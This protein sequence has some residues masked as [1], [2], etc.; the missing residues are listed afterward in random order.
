MHSNK[1][2][3]KSE[4]IKN[5][6]SDNIH[7]TESGSKSS[8]KMANKKNAFFKNNAI[9]S[10]IKTSISTNGNSHTTNEIKDT[11][12]ECSDDGEN[13]E[14][15]IISKKKKQKMKISNL[16]RKSSVNEIFGNSKKRI[17]KKSNSIEDPILL[18]SD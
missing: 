15:N 16:K 6:N 14:R 12:V 7:I 2:R 18:D 8:T 13:I 1:E 17:V 9:N 10:S 4:Q 11:N 3:N 5:K